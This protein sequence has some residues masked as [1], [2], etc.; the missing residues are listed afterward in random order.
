[1]EYYICE[2]CG[3]KIVRRNNL[4]RHI[5]EKHSSTI[6]VLKCSYCQRPFVRKSNLKEHYVRVHKLCKENVKNEVSNCKSTKM[7][8]QQKEDLKPVFVMDPAY[9]DISSDEE[10]ND[11]I[12][13]N[14]QSVTNMCEDIAS[15]DEFN[16][17]D[18]MDLC[19]DSEF[20][21]S[22]NESADDIQCILE[23]IIATNPGL[24]DHEDP[25]YVASTKEEEKEEEVI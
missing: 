5:R 14:S 6:T 20:L 12:P 23:D 7:P 16:L 2:Y 8:Y 18:E 17:M 19:M 4:V 11:E 9:E 24:V 13:V 15:D 21:S 3:I 25:P 10:F 1:M 22:I